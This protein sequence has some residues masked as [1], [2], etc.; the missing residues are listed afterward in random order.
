ML[1]CECQGDLA[2]LRRR[3]PNRIEAFAARC[4]LE[5]IE[6]DIP[7][8]IDIEMYRYNITTCG[9]Y[10]GFRRTDS[11]GLRADTHRNMNR[12]IHTDLAADIVFGHPPYV[13]GYRLTLFQLVSSQC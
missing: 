12:L 1:I 10:T 13:S 11:Y 5:N 2:G 3:R 6:C 8:I 4:H 9:C 7:N